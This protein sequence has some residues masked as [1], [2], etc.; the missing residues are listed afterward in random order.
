MPRAHLA[1]TGKALA[2]TLWT[3]HH[4]GWPVPKGLGLALA[5]QLCPG[6]SVTLSTVFLSLVPS[7]FASDPCRDFQVATSPRDPAPD[8]LQGISEPL[9]VPGVRPRLPPYEFKC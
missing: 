7:F 3:V 6:G 5:A 9:E 8:K 1:K 2:L 4:R